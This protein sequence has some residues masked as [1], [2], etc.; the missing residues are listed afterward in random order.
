VLTK[1][2]TLRRRLRGAESGCAVGV[3]RVRFSRRG[4]GGRGEACGSD[5][6]A[7]D[8]HRLANAI[9]P[10]AKGFDVSNLR[11]YYSRALNQEQFML[12]QQ[13]YQ[14]IM[15]ALLAIEQLTGR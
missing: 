7:G 9:H 2:P 6:G 13:R 8:Q 3:W 4:E 14:N 1:E 12:L 5:G 10:A 15:V 11:G